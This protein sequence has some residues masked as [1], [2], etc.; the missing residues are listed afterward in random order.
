MRL[1]RRSTTDPGAAPRQ[2]PASGL[3]YLHL[4]FVGWTYYLVIPV[5][6]GKLGLF[7]AVDSFNLMSR[8]AQPHDPWWPVLIAY[9]LVLPLGFVAGALAGHRLPR[10][11]EPP[12]P[13]AQS[14]RILLPL[15]AVALVFTGIQARG[16]LFT[17]YTEGVDIGAAGPI[18]TLQM[19]ML[20]QYLAA[21]AARLR[22]AVG[23]G[24]LLIVSSVLLLAMGGRLYV[25]SALVAIYVY[26]WKYSATSA[27][28]RRRSLG[29]IIAVPLVFAMVGMWRLGTFDITEL[30][31]YVFAEP[32][33]T[34]ISAFTL[35]DGHGWSFFDAP[36]DFVSAFLNIVP[37]AIW[38]EKSRLVVSI[39][40]S[41][42]QF[43]APFGAVSIVTSTI[44]NFGVVG[45]VAFV[46]FVG[47]V[48]ERTRLAAATPMGRA[49]YC[50]LCCLLP[51]MFFRDPYQVQV[52]VVL[53]GFLLVWVNR[54]LGIPW[55]RQADPVRDAP[56]ET[57]DSL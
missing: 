19:A 33:F 11:R 21:K 46:A 55:S 15:Y 43:D 7:D 38:P 3:S 14:T 20:L 37:T 22:A 16:S 5:L 40:D 27:Q 8:Y 4:F 50:Y 24:A 13:L 41:P 31:F 52:K 2:A 18:A 28:A 23:L 25:L 54:L 48:M 45:G 35:M 53:T 39:I 30:G 29:A 34:S 42:L 36:R 26:W 51:F 6:A 9:V 12:T 47:F 49:L 17:G 57:A 44:G 32:M 1:R 10:L 56:L